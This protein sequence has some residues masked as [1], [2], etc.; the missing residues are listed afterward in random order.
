MEEKC[1]VHCLE[2]LSYLSQTFFPTTVSILVLPSHVG[3]KHQDYLDK[4]Q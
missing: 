1:Q 3:V 4:S 2:Q